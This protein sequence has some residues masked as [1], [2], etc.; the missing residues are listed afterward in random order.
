VVCRIGR[1]P[2]MLRRGAQAHRRSTTAG[3]VDEHRSSDSD[4]M[5]W[6]RSAYPFGLGATRP[7]ITCAM[8]G[9]RLAIAFM[10]G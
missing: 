1:T 2:V 6:F 10:M 5:T 8:I 3:L 7:L 4:L 9:I